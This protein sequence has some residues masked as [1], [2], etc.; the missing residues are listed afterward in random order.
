MSKIKRG[1]QAKDKSQYDDEINA[2]S[3]T[4]RTHQ[5]RDLYLSMQDLQTNFRHD[6]DNKLLGNDTPFYVDNYT[7]GVRNVTHFGINTSSQSVQQEIT[8]IQLVTKLPSIADSSRCPAQQQVQ[9]LQK[10]RQEAITQLI[11]SEKELVKF[12][13]QTCQTGEAV[14]VDFIKRDANGK[15]DNS[16][17]KPD[18]HT[19][20]LFEQNSK[21]LIVDPS[22]AE[23]S[24]ILMGADDNIRVLCTN[25]PTQ[26][27]KRNGDPGPGHD[28]WRDCVDVAVK[29]AF[30]VQRALSHHE[31]LLEVK[32]LDQASNI[33]IIDLKSFTKCFVI[34]DLT[35]NC[36][37]YQKLGTWVE[38]APSRL[39]QSTDFKEA[40]KAC[41]YSKA[42]KAVADRIDEVD[43]T[44]SYHIQRDIQNK[45]Y[46][47]LMSHNTSEM[48]T[49]LDAFTTEYGMQLNEVCP[50][51][52]K[53]IVY[54]DQ[55]Q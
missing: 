41:A 6:Q 23:F 44:D 15:I 46:G 42:L 9:S 45:I 26:I 50:M 10:L 19:V 27:Y 21:F 37:V 35:N 51:L 7:D 55:L 30:G 52:G 5:H 4:P 12:A 48:R 25:K 20:V 8:S 47:V 39:K 49:A 17:S 2:R 38:H 31:P 3:L 33:G 29:I 32:E 36:S 14:L 1:L 54:I 18:I 11:K 22:N 13:L 34:R 28:K 53:E 40:K 16:Q 24:R 43:V